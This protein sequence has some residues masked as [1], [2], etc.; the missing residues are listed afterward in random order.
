MSKNLNV[1]LNFTANTSQAKT[2]IQELSNL[3]TKVAYSN[4]INVN[5][6]SIK[7]ASQAAKELAY[8]LGQAYN[9]NTG[10]YD[11]SK[12]NASLQKSG[13]NVQTLSA[14]L[15]KAGTTGQ[16]AFI[17]LAQVISTADQPV[18]KINK[19]LAEMWTTLKNTA[20]WQ[21]SSSFLHGFQ[22]AVR[23]AYGYAQD[24]NESLNKIRIVTGAN[25]DEMARFADQANKA[26]KALS[27]TTTRYTDAAL[28]YYQQGL[29]DNEVIK[30]TD[31]TVKMANV[32]GES[33]DEVS[34]Y[35]T[36]IWNNFDDGS[37][38]LEYFAD[39]I[40]KLGAETAAS[41]A[42]IANGL[43]KFAAIGETIG[44]SYEYATAALT[45]IIDK[46]RQSE[47]V[48]GTALKTIFA[49]IQGLQMGGETEDGL[50][51]NKY[52]S[53]LAVYGISIFNANNELRD[54]DEILD[55]MGAKWD[56]LNRA[57][58]VGLAQTVAGVRQY[59][60]LMSL[61]DNWDAMQKNVGIAS[62][63][64]GSLQEQ[65]DIYA[66]S[67]D[68][69]SNRVRAALESIYSDMV[70]DDFFID[71]YD[72][73]ADIINGVDD[74]VDS[75]G[76]MK[77]VLLGFGTIFLSLVKSKIGPAMQDLALNVKVITGG[78]QVAY[79]KI[80]E[81]TSK[82]VSDQLA[83]GNYNDYQERQ[84]TNAQQLMA[85]KNKL[86]IVNKDLSD[87]ERV[88]YEIAINGLQ[89]QQ[90]E[91]LELIQDIEK[92][93]Q[94]QEAAKDKGFSFSKSDVQSATQMGRKLIER[95]F[96]NATD[97][98]EFEQEYKLSYMLDE[99]ETYALEALEQ[100]IYKVTDAWYDYNNA[101]TV[102]LENK[103][104]FQ[105]QIAN[106]EN[107]KNKLHEIKDIDTI[108][109]A[110]RVQVEALPLDT[111]K[112]LAPILGN[113]DAAT[114]LKGVRNHLTALIKEIGK[115][116][117]AGKDL[118]KVLQG[119]G[120]PAKEI[121]KSKKEIQ[122]LGEK[123][124]ESTERIKHL[125]EQAN[126]F[127][128]KHTVKT[129][130][131]LTAFTAGLGSFAMLASSVKSAYDTMM[132][133]DVSGL[134]KAISLMMTF[135]M[136]GTSIIGMVNNFSKALTWLTETQLF[137]NATLEYTNIKT[138]A[139][140]LATI[141]NIRANENLNKG[142]KVV[143]IQRILC[144]K[145]IEKDT[146]KKIANTIVTKGLTLETIKLIA[147][148]MGLKLAT[149]SLVAGVAAFVAIAGIAIALISKWHISQKELNKSFDEYEEAAKAV[150][151]LDN[152][153]QN[154]NNS[155]DEL[156]SKGLSELT[157]EER[158][159]LS[160]LRQQRAELEGQKKIAESI[161]KQELNDFV[162]D[163]K[164]R[165]NQDSFNNY[166]SE[167]LNVHSNDQQL[168]NRENAESVLGLN[169]LGAINA[170]DTAAIDAYENKVKD[171]MR[172]G[173]IDETNQKHYDILL[174]E[175]NRL[176]NLGA[177]NAEQLQTDYQQAKAY[178]QSDN[179]D[180][181]SEY[182]LKATEAIAKYYDYLGD[183]INFKDDIVELYGASEDE[184][185]KLQGEV[186]GKIEE[187]TEKDL[188][189]N[190]PREFFN[191]LS[192]MSEETGLSLVYLADKLGILAESANKLTQQDVFDNLNALLSGKKDSDGKSYK[193]DILTAHGFKDVEG[194]SIN[195]GENNLESI[196]TKSGLS[197]Q[198]QQDILL[199]I[200]WTNQSQAE[201]VIE[202]LKQIEEMTSDKSMTQEA[203]S[204]GYSEE[205]FEAMTAGIMRANEAFKDNEK[206]AKQAAI[207]QMRLSKAV[208]AASEIW[209]DYGDA[210]K[211]ADENNSDYY[212]GLGALAEVFTENLG[213]EVDWASI[214][215]HLEL[216]KLAMEGDADAAAELSQQLAFDDIDT[217][218]NEVTEESFENLKSSI[219]DA[220]YYTDEFINGS[221]DSVIQKWEET[222]AFLDQDLEIG[223]I[224][225]DQ[226]IHSLNDM[227][228]AAGMTQEEAQN[229][230][231]SIGYEGELE[232]QPMEMPET[233][234]HGTF[235]LPLIGEVEWT[236]IQDP[237]T[238]HVPYIKDGTL[239]KSATKTGLKNVSSGSQSKSSG[240]SKKDMER[241]H[242]VSNQ[243]ETLEDQYSAIGSAREQ[244]FGADKLAF[245]DQEIAKLDQIIEKNKEYL[246]QI[247][248]NLASDKAKMESYGAK[249]D[250]NG[251]ITNYR[252]IFKKYGQNEEFQKALEN[253]EDSVDKYRKKV[254]EINEELREWQSLNFERL[255]YVVEL[256]LDLN[257]DELQE[258]DYYYNKLGDNVYKSAECFAL[259]KDKLDNTEDSLEIHKQAVSDLDA[260]FAAG[261]ISQ[262]DYIEGIREHKDAIYEN[263]EALQEY[264]EQLKEFYGE[265][266]EKA[267]DELAEYIDQFDVLS[268][269]LEHY[270]NILELTGQEQDF[271]KMA[272]ILEGSA[273]VTEDKLATSAEWY[274]IQKQNLADLEAEYAR[275]HDETIKAA[276][277]AQRAA[278][279][280]AYDAML[281][282]AEEYAEALNDI[283]QNEVAA[284][285]ETLEK[286]LSG[287][288]GFDR[289]NASMQHMSD[290]QDEYLTKT[291]QIYE[292]NK[293]LNSLNNDIN[294]TN[295]VASKQKLNA[296]AKEI[297]Q[298]QE[299]DKLSNLELEIAQAKYKQMQAQ[300]ALEEAQNAKSV[301][302]LSRD[303]EG[304]Y[305]Y[306]YTSD[307]EAISG[308]EQELADAENDL[309]NIR[310]KGANEYGEKVIQLN[311]WI[312]EELA[313]ID[314]DA[315]LTQEQ[316]NELK[317][318][319][320]NQYYEK[321]NMYTD[322]Y[323]I[324]QE[325]DARVVDDAWVNAYSDI[326]LNGEE[327]KNAI[328]AYN[329]ETDESFNNL[330]SNLATVVEL[331]G[332]D[333]TTLQDK[334]DKV[335]SASESL[336]NEI[337]TQVIPALD[338]ELDLV[339]EQI[340]QHANEE[341]GIED[342]EYAYEKL[343]K[344]IQK[345]I[346]EYTKLETA[347]LEAAAAMAKAANAG[348]V[349]ST[350]K[351][352]E[353][354]EKYDPPEVKY[355]MKQSGYLSNK[356]DGGERINIGANTN[357][358]KTADGKGYVSYNGKW[359]LISDL[360]F[361][362]GTAQGGVYKIP[363][364]GS[365]PYYSYVAMDTGGY[366]G[367]WGPEGKLAM[368][369]EKEIVLNKEDSANIL[370]V[371]EIV[372]AM[373]DTNAANAGIGV[374]HSPGINTQNQNLE[375]TVT[376][377]AEFPNAT[378]HSEIEMAFDS[379]MNRAT[380]YA[381]RK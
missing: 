60:Q 222:K 366:T 226:Y 362:A 235:T 71:V 304:N 33:A 91:V 73:L 283:Y 90:E 110:I 137:Y 173:Q 204:L 17:K 256:K 148:E 230:L 205:Q 367:E 244:A 190:L 368:L 80:N 95:R 5:S 11:L 290:I 51:L 22:R 221:L 10:N 300:I 43:E 261:E 206:L 302:R 106:L 89:M 276:L 104:L 285:Q 352:K 31:T 50:S 53:A 312:A 142:L 370:K 307:Q 268:N 202:V 364:K 138:V 348:N 52:S 168:N 259:L 361:V 140:T 12:L 4:N 249:F 363:E 356:K 8:H 128:P 339:K 194:N 19:H 94:A 237:T 280:E 197:F 263:L 123:S 154:V 231:S 83:T 380:Q 179:I 318:E 227:I 354:E 26:A 185:N 223:E 253:Y 135:S 87:A 314:N 155:I 188:E 158:E 177:D 200:D 322:L 97:S 203:I 174:D 21:I 236:H 157:E 27:T 20:R 49:R 243:L 247:E 156:L 61:M 99:Q 116:T 25:S 335:T 55:D 129:A 296:F 147:A 130:E 44:L 329:E 79:N 9:K 184:L 30:R 252:T 210:L 301:V 169:G 328:T 369:H 134:E 48:V 15:V 115:G 347:A 13:K 317:A 310:L 373:I 151:E 359:L 344:K 375:Q 248:K 70:D 186:K 272:A 271:E 275:T 102:A 3:L 219:Q 291:N 150:K 224:V 36:A 311:Q 374:L 281:S 343:C 153:L 181:E 161:K 332:I 292:T 176:R 269:A 75:I 372:R 23:S 287:G 199:N 136:M 37:K 182:Y 330:Q 149:L 76:G 41:S 342:L 381:N 350:P 7:A 309:Y 167:N 351:G 125:Q 225:D 141:L 152:E 220:S 195:L 92:L 105:G 34:S 124:K 327:C 378:N 377:T 146:A 180:K 284:A 119:L 67:W 114:D 82:A 78:A 164:K 305:G 306:V 216:V 16:Q 126:D 62:G 313:K 127:N 165:I 163:F 357:N 69:A 162:S 189:E 240:G 40:T 218:L 109:S 358:T 250:E 319:L 257:E 65:A 353:P 209:N 238:I 321:L 57:Q 18:L 81:D 118:E 85:V 241:Y 133:P 88:Q 246:S 183:A 255:N 326:I 2:Q 47:D 286:L 198:E 315:T 46:T 212:E 108:K 72:N 264:E 143:N 132:N 131:A 56:T 266:L 345:T 111:K 334:V 42:E 84:L 298:L 289:L 299:K 172:S 6:N 371:V 260:A 273:A 96:A 66:E 192:L 320:L 258:L 122:E 74:F 303:N 232:T 32:T 86:N 234:S 113:I 294:K 45:T 239:K 229:Y 282:D 193:E 336:R 337:N 145:G 187:I 39:V 288:L 58:K 341:Q 35:M 68:A 120:T 208:D 308:A 360:T 293:L 233:V 355:G 279:A 64:E 207:Y 251:D 323:G 98:A 278:T 24:L 63:S 297:E 160:L 166:G 54:M 112:S 274:E 175:I 325:E 270:K 265:T 349:S 59:N 29:S 144:S 277:D 101:K 376:I 333:L 215:E 191:T 103:D 178:L 379:L 107:L 217:R 214:E 1:A 38:S 338:D 213:F 228:A 100:T 242:T 316:R 365:I 324:A 346:T 170:L 77:T 93:K 331:V 28:I 245:Y 201:S 14:E 159:Q 211:E 262:A 139:N 254:E 295:N 117:I 171:L 267:K 121:K 196:L 340:I